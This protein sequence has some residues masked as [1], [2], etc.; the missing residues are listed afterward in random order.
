MGEVSYWC[1]VVTFDNL[2]LALSSSKLQCFLICNMHNV[3]IE[4]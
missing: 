4:M 2:L 1:S 3:G